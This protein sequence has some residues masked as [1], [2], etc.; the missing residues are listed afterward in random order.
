MNEIEY[1]IYL[2]AFIVG[3]ITGLLLSYKKHGETFIYNKIEIVPLTIAIIGWT[4]LFNFVLVSIIPSVIIIALALFLISTV[5][6][7]RP[8]Y[9]RYETAI[10]VLISIAIWSI[11]YL[12][13]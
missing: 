2:L 4:L 13:S 1:L 5:L 3:A 6:G 7:M 9:G 12:T 10:G 11:S 8:G